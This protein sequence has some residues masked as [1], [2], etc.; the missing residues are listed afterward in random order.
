MEVDAMFKK[1]VWATDGS[2]AADEALPLAR[3]LA[4]EALPT[5]VR[6]TGLTPN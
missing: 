6:E 1:V 2:D 5:R 4:A 3:A